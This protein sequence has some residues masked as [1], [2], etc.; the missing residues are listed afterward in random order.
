MK[1]SENQIDQISLEHDIINNKNAANSLF[2][3]L[4]SIVRLQIYNRRNRTRSFEEFKHMQKIPG[5]TI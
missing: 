2:L 5:K 3:L 1:N 4:I